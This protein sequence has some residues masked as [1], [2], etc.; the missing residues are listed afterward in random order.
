MGYEYGQRKVTLFGA[1]MTFGELRGSSDYCDI[2]SP[3]L[4]V[5]IFRQCKQTNYKTDA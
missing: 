5:P 4:C 2:T 1:V 3:Y